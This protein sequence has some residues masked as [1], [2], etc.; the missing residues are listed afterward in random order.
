MEDKENKMQSIL[1]IAIAWI[2]ALAIFFL[3]VEKIKLLFNW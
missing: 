1:I 3:V 2:I